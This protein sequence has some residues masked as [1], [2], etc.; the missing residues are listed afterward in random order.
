MDDDEEIEIANEYAHY[1]SR[2]AIAADRRHVYFYIFI[3]LLNIIK[4]NY[5]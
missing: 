4:Y 5:W 3:K 2:D 1:T